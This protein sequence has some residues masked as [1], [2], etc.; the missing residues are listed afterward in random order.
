MAKH[1]WKLQL[2]TF[3]SL[4]L[5]PFIAGA[6]SIPNPIGA[7]NFTDLIDKITNFIFV[8][9]LAIAPI[10]IIVAG[11]M[12]VL[13]Q[14]EP[15]KIKQAKDMILWVLIGLLVVFAAKGIIQLFQ[16]ILTY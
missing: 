2:F 15:D 4:L 16:E 3:L 6:V 5:I 11:F 9:A 8:L 1:F 13:A 14:G 10:M 7:E 12:F